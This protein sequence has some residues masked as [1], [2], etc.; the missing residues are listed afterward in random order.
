MPEQSGPPSSLGRPLNDPRRPRRLV[1]QSVGA[2]LLRMAIMA[3]DPAPLDGEPVVQDQKLFPELLV[4]NF[5]S[6]SIAPSLVDPAE[7]KHSHAV[8][9]VLRIGP[10]F[11]LRPYGQRRKCSNGGKKLH[12]LN[13]RPRLGS[14]YLPTPLVLHENGAPSAG[15]GIPD[16]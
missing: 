4:P 8:D 16:C 10:E 11:D 1:S 5:L 12:L 2:R 15:A 3:F 14:G 9:E 13:R 7:N 6:A